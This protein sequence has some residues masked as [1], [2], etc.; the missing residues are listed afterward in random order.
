MLPMPIAAALLSIDSEDDRQYCADVYFRYRDKLLQYA[1][2]KTASKQD[3]EDAVQDTML[4]LIDRIDQ[5][6][7]FDEKR[8]KGYLFSTLYHFLV[9]KHR[10]R[11]LIRDP[12]EELPDSKTAAED[13]I[14]QIMTIEELMDAIRQLDEESIMLIQMRY[15]QQ[16]KDSEISRIMSVSETALRSRFTRIRRRLRTLMEANES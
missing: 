15:F 11:L 3:A 10:K 8:L 16:L 13:E 5:L 9:M 6:R 14:I 7:N 2:R 1:G 4:V 12:A